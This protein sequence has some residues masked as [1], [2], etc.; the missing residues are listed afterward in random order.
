LNTYIYVL[1]FF[2]YLLV[3]LKKMN[4]K[5]LL[6]HVLINT[7]QPY[8]FIF[9]FLYTDVGNSGLEFPLSIS[10]WLVVSLYTMPCITKK[11]KQNSHRIAPIYISLGTKNFQRRKQSKNVILYS[12]FF[13]LLFYNCG[14]KEWNR[15]N[16]KK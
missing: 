3:F 15:N 5:K 14:L 8:I 4:T 1:F 16:K 11:L 13:F 6:F 9:L 10:V 7:Y 12:I 2:C